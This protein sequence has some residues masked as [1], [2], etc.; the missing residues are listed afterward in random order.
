MS[1]DSR[2]IAAAAAAVMEYLA[3]ENREEPRVGPL[4]AVAASREQAGRR[5]APG[6]LWSLQGRSD[7]MQLRVLMQWKALQRSARP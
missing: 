2:K 5:D 6:S 1:R 3:A 7:L 4:L